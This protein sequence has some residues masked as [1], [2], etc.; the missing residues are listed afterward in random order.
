[1]IESNLEVGGAVVFWSASA[2][3]DRDKL[4]AG[5]APL[6]LD[7]F[8]PDPRPHAS[9]LRDALE[10][11]LGG[12]R[13]LVRPLAD[14]D[15]FPTSTPTRPEE[16]AMS[17]ATNDRPQRKQLADQIDRLDRILDGLA[18]GLNDAIADAC[19]EGTRAA[20]REAVAEVLATPD[21]RELTRPAAA[22][23]RGPSFWSRVKAKFAELKMA[24]AALAERAAAAVTTRCRSAGEVAITTART[25]GTAWRLRRLMLAGLG[26]GVVAVI[27][28]A[29]NMIA[30]AVISIHA[31][32]IATI[33][34]AW[35]W[36]R[37]RVRR[38]R[39]A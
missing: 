10:E 1:M 3:T 38:L 18:E 33:V 13:V 28:A 25:L 15:G 5:L 32:A 20:V 14:R 17:A 7:H 21:L 9:V 29:P 27:H 11:A 16:S 6:G 12:P 8:V 22:A 2:F 34:A 24:A 39:P 30:T 31:E 4:T 35:V 26:V 37:E 36:V 19:K 23:S